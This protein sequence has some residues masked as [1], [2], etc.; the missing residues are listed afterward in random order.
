MSQEVKVIARVDT[1]QASADIRR[2]ESSFEEMR[3]GFS[4]SKLV[5]NTDGFENILSITREISNGMGT[6][7]TETRQL[8]RETGE[9]SVAAYRVVDNYEQLERVIQRNE[10]EAEKLSNQMLK[11]QQMRERENAKAE[12]AAARSLAS[13]KEEYQLANRLLETEQ[14]LAE[15][16]ERRAKAEGEA[17]Q[18]R[19]AQQT[20]AS[21]LSDLEHAFSYA[22]LEEYNQRNAPF[23]SGTNGIYTDTVP[24]QQ[25]IDALTGVDREQSK[26]NETTSMF[27]TISESSYKKYAAQNGLAREAQ[28]GFGEATR[29]AEE[30]MRKAQEQAEKSSR[31]YNFLSTVLYRLGHTVITQVTKGFRE[32]LQE[33]KAVDSE[34]V[35]VRK[36]T[37]ASAEELEALRDRAYEVG[38][39]YGVVA[40]DYLSAAAEFSRAGYK[41]QAGDLAE[42]ATKLQLVGD[43]SQDIA[44]QFLIATDKAYGLNGNYEKLS[45]VIDELNEIDNNFATSIEKVAQGLGTVAPVAAQAH[46]SVEELSAAIGTITATTQ[47]SGSEAARALRAIFLNVMGDTQTEVEEG[48][49]VTKE[50]IESLKDALQEYAPE[51]VK[52][53][54]ATGTLINPMTAIASLADAYER[55]LISEQKLMAIVTDIGGKLRSSQLMAL[56]QNWGMYEEML[57]KTATA[58]GSA[59]R[60]VQNA[61]DSWEV[62]LNILKNTW[63]DFVQETLSTGFIKKSLDGLTWLIESFGNLG[64][65]IAIVTPALIAFRMQDIVSFA[66]KGQVALWNFAAA[67]TGTGDAATVASARLSVAAAIIAGIIIA[68]NAYN[69][70]LDDAIAKGSEARKSLDNLETLYAKYE[71]LNAEAANTEAAKTARDDLIDKLIDEGVWVDSVIGKYETLDEKI[72]AATQS[73]I[74]NRRVELNDA[75][76][77][78]KTKMFWASAFNTFVP[79]VGST[80]AV[81]K[82]LGHSWDFALNEYGWEDTEKIV[83]LY[84]EAIEKRK[85]FAKGIGGAPDSRED[86]QLKE[87][88]ERYGDA[89]SAYKSAKAALEELEKVEETTAES[90]S[91]LSD[92]TQKA[93]TDFIGLQDE[94]EGVTKAL[95]AYQNKLKE[96]EKGEA[97]TSYAEAFK[98]AKEMF[99]KGLTGTNAYMSAIDLLLPPELLEQLGYNY[100][101]AGELIGSDFFT[102]LF[103][104]GGEDFGANAAKFLRD[105]ADSFSRFLDVTDNADGSFSIA[106]T[107]IEGL[108]KAL[109]ISEDALWAMIDAWDAFD[110]SVTVSL[111][112]LRKIVEQ[113]GD[114]TTG[115]IDSMTLINDLVANGKSAAEIHAI[116]DGLKQM[117]GVKLENL[118]KNLTDTIDKIKEAN[119]EFDGEKNAEIVL[120]SNADEFFGGIYKEIETLD[121]KTIYIGIKYKDVEQESSYIDPSETRHGS[122]VSRTSTVGSSEINFKGGNGKSLN[123]DFDTVS[124]YKVGV[125]SAKAGLAIVNEEGAELIQKRGS[126][127]LYIANGG[128][129]ALVKLDAGDSV[130]TAEETAELYDP[131]FKKGTSALTSGTPKKGATST[132]KFPTSEL[133]KADADSTSPKSSGGGGG[134]SS[135]DSTDWLDLL[136][137]YM[138]DLLKK[139]KQSL[140]EQ[141]AVLEETS[142]LEEARLNMLKAEKGLADA[143]AERTVRYYNK[144]TGQ[145]EWMADQKAVQSASE[146]LKDAQKSYLETQYKALEDAWKDIQDIIKRAMEGTAEL[147]GAAILAALGASA[148]GGSLSDVQTLISNIGSFT[149]NPL[150]GINTSLLDYTKAASLLYPRSMLDSGLNLNHSL[151]ALYG[152]STADPNAKGTNLITTMDRS[153]TTYGA[154][155]YINGVK[156]GSDMMD[157]PLSQILSVLP[158]YAN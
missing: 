70:S 61:L 122:R 80:D 113:Y 62:K 45:K 35:V 88:I 51:V 121:G 138:S 22:G 29:K 81:T 137:D 134:G 54:E 31:S 156:I 65:V 10:K 147:D 18:R 72:K 102:A 111:D 7:I 98:S 108:S 118:P 123:V 41:D 14:R 48:E 105:N 117:E 16:A 142:E 100:E 85:E 64:T 125:D 84:D 146:S 50:Q 13:Q 19:Y 148:A 89:V 150:G 103:E 77:A 28:E 8:N 143:N 21:R 83:R 87:F 135:A 93:K 132:F 109:N 90:T 78:A 112:D 76:E 79:G 12:A 23:V 38:K 47:R 130:Y 116:L 17:A 58:A 127:D 74:D 73:S 129:P 33:M 145:W 133:S 26:I 52:A 39:A 136:D 104:E 1:N 99:E 94:I 139:A 40:S 106:I 154:T 158:I 92:S 107:D 68:I 20:H 140:D 37:G 11:Q 6:V 56:I 126:K 119:E 32:A 141:Y 53:A 44:N 43:V 151:S 25:Y 128:N 131:R 124:M 114:A 15:E 155:Y 59:D 5:I 71:K 4:R 63:T 66:Q 101:K 55:G 46:V 153:S 97:L 42:L 9:I 157:K 57:E 120:T 91:D 96:G 115:A 152:I 82:I 69:K 24:I 34:L 75:Y 3:S 67:F 27:A 30:R 144:A 49:T 2:L 86:N 36:V 110:S 149:S 95:E 60:E